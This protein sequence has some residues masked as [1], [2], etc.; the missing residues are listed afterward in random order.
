MLGVVERKKVILPNLLERLW[1]DAEH[2]DPAREK[3]SERGDILSH[4]L[5][6]R[7]VLYGSR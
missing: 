3:Q 5:Y 7:N 1:M 6:H 2:F 4:A